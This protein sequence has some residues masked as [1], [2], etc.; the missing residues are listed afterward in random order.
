LVKK[1]AAIAPGALFVAPICELAGDDRVY[2]GS[3][4]GVAEK[5]DW[6]SDLL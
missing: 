5:V 6:V 3:D 1:Y 4:F 2:V